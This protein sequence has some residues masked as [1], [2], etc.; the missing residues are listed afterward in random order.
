MTGLCRA[1]HPLTRRNGKSVCRECARDASRDLDRL[2]GA[3][4]RHLG[5]TRAA[6]R[7]EHGSVRRVAEAVLAGPPAPPRPETCARG[8]VRTP[9]NT[10]WKRSRGRAHRYCTACA[11][12]RDSAALT[13]ISAAAEQAGLTSAEW[14]RRHGGNRSSAAAAAAA[15]LHLHGP[16]PRSRPESRARD[17]AVRQARAATRAR[18][19]A[20]GRTH[21]AHLDPDQPD[22]DGLSV[23][24]VCSCGWRETHATPYR[25]RAALAEHTATRPDSAYV[26][27]D[28]LDS[29]Q[30]SA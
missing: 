15:Q 21:I 11:R 3:A 10:G 9:E 27:G 22:W 29:W 19:A 23:L 13:T 7:A 24:A 16:R 5:L 25:A 14:I 12:E 18:V 4:A 8:H 30:E 6:Y 28:R 17:E 2:I 1:G 20:S 26:R